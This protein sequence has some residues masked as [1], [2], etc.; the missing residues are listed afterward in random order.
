ME[1]I[2]FCKVQY[3]KVNTNFKDSSSRFG[4]YF[5]ECSENYFAFL[6]SYFVREGGVLKNEFRFINA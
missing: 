4:F 5:K 2:K 3:K 1:D 6:D